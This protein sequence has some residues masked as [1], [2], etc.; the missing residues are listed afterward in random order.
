M[1]SVTNALRKRARRIRY[2]FIC[3]GAGCRNKRTETDNGYELL[4]GRKV[5][6]VCYRKY[7]KEK[8]DD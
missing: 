8:K 4:D 2:Y 5:C 6:M 1:G 3:E 7:Q